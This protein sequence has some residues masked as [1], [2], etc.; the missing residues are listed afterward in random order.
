M[1]CLLADENFN[2]RI[3]RALR[4]RLPDLNVVR[5]QDTELYRAKDPAVLAWAADEGRVVLSHD[6]ATLASAAYERMQAG[7]DMPG[8]VL[9]PSDLAIGR[10]IEDLELLIAAGRAA[11]FGNRVIFLPL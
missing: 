4:R 10:V 1:L 11:D 9:A 2:G 8:V 3:L 7:L 5:V 6:V